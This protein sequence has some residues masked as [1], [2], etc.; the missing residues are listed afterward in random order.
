MLELEPDLV[1]LLESDAIILVG[2]VAADGLPE[3]SRGWGLAVRPEADPPEVRL[4]MPV[5]SARARENLE[6]TGRIAITVT[7]VETLRSAQVKGRVARFEPATD[8]DARAHERSFTALTEA[9]QRADGTDP[10]LFRRVKPGALT[11]VIA[12]LE[13]VYDQTPGP[14]AGVRLAPSADAP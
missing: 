4:L 8:A 2:T 5:A 6:T 3:A 9:L 11:A 10:E 12:T 7:D 1:T 13:E 14:A